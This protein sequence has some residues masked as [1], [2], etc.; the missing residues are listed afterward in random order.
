[1]SLGSFYRN[2][3]ERTF[4]KLAVDFLMQPNIKNE[5]VR[6]IN[7][8]LDSIHLPAL[9]MDTRGDNRCITLALNVIQ[10]LANKEVAN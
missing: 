1:M 4:R 2:P 6:L 9:N 3:Y 8:A 7:D 5:H 10:S